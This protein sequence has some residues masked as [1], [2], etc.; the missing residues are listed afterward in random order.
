MGI[1]V[2]PKRA[3]YLLILFP[4]I[5]S[6]S[7]WAE[8]PSHSVQGED[9]HFHRNVIAGFVGITDEDRRERALT[10]GLDYN[11]W[12]TRSFGIGFG[13]ERAFGDLD[14]TVY[15]LPFSYRFGAWKLFAAPGW[16]D[17][18]HYESIDH[19][20]DSMHAGSTEFLVR[21]G[22]EYAFEVGRY[23]LSPKFMIDYIDDD[24]VLVGGLSIGYGF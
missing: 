1:E 5:G 21:A 19:G 20:E 8:E 9:E 18:G 3:M 6:V 22:V 10:L 23:E 12:V 11:R 2:N 14:F 17:S 4:A 24:F 15:T 16:E 13:I 7:A